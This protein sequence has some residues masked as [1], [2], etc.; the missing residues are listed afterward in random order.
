[1]LN[2]TQN[3]P[4]TVSAAPYTTTHD[5]VVESDTRCNAYKRVIVAILTIFFVRPIRPL[6]PP[7][8]RL[9]QGYY[10]C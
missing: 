6:I 1:M 3:T 8:L 4:N 7:A 10:P 9:E 5:D 2:S